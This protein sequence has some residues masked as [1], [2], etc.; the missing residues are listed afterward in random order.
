MKIQLLSS[1]ELGFVQIASLEQGEAFSAC[2]EKAKYME[3]PVFSL[4]QHCFELTSPDYDYYSPF[5]F[6]Q[7]QIVTLRNHLV[8][9]QAR[10]TAVSNADDLENFILKHFAGIEFMNALKD[11]DQ[12]WKISWEKIKN[13]LL[14]VGEELIEIVDNCIDEDFVLWVKGF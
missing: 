7:A 14:Q 12:D 10:I 4:Y 9:N 3:S 6:S 11:E 2:P 8:T 5:S 1:E 13:K